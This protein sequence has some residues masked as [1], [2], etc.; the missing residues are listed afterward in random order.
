MV[1]T[2]TL[3]RSDEVQFRK[4]SGKICGAASRATER[5]LNSRLR[6]RFR[7]RMRCTVRYLGPD[8]SSVLETS[9]GT[10]D[11]STTGLGL[12][13]RCRFA[14][15]T[16]LHVVVSLPLGRSTDLTGRVVFAR[17][18]RWGW[19]HVGMVLEPVD[20]YPS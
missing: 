5:T 15:G 8:G 20:G 19:Y 4:L 14:P 13:T 7:F 12:I 2:D 1:A 10:R 11:I 18:I 3:V 6:E 17:L 9:G 16:G